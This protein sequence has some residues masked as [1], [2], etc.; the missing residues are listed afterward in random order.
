MQVCKHAEV[1]LELKGRTCANEGGHMLEEGGCARGHGGMQTTRGRHM[2]V[3]WQVEVHLKVKGWRLREG[4]S[5]SKGVT[6]NSAGKLK[7]TWN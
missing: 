2:R 1:H 7:C 3:H 5:P 4:Q 6:C